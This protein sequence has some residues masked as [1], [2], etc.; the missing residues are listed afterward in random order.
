MCM[1]SRVKI[2]ELCV[3]LA[4]IIPQDF[5]AF[6]IFGD[7]EKLN[8]YCDVLLKICDMEEKFLDLL[9]IL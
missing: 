9:D 4:R 2:T 8:P 5:S 7:K 3:E 1:F 6:D